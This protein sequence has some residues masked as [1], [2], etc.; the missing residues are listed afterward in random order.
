[1]KNEKVS[2]ESG[3]PL[4]CP[5]ADGALRPVQASSRSGTPVMLDQCERCGGVWFDKYE[6]FQVDEDEARGLDQVDR[7]TLRYPQGS[8]E[9]PLC[10]RCGAMLEAFSDPN[11]PA[12][13]QMLMCGNCE[14]FWIN[15]GDIG[16]YA[17]YREAGHSRLDPKLAAQ[18][19]SMLQ[20]QSNKEYW[21]GIENFGNTVS[22]PR[23]MLTGLPLR[24]SPAEQDRID[25][26]QDA[27]FTMLGIAARLLFGWL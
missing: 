11:I 13:I 19:E 6:L 18:Y 12:N 17:D 27:F 25:R 4:R 5:N 10:P 15:H 7:E 9:K 8:S 21:Q 1:M 2:M 20:S 26:T 16:G 23:D 3:Q 22:G 24:G 14:G